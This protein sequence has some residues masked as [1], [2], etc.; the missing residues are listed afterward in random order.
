[1][2]LLEHARELIDQN[3]REL[4]IFLI[5]FFAGALLAF[6]AMPRSRQER[7]AADIASAKALLTRARSA[8]RKDSDLH[9]DIDAFIEKAGKR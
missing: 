6:M 8:L 5:C 2:E 4:L 7:Y 3:A 1:M 9:S